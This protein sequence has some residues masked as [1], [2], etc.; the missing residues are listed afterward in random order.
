MD[1]IYLY[2]AQIIA[3]LFVLL[4][5]SLIVLIRIKGELEI[6]K[7][8][9]SKTNEDYLKY[10]TDMVSYRKWAIETYSEYGNQCLQYAKASKETLLIYMLWIEKNYPHINDEFYNH[11]NTQQTH[12]NENIEGRI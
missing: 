6:E 8:F 5:I 11:I 2:P 1:F 4:I 7:E 9:S 3:I 10:I 12:E